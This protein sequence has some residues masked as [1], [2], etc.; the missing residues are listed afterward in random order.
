MHK[1]HCS[2][3][4]LHSIFIIV[5]NRLLHFCPVKY[6]SSIHVAILIIIQSW[7]QVPTI[8]HI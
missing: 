8:W 6:C 1:F 4:Q 5:T 7:M 3:N 2:Q